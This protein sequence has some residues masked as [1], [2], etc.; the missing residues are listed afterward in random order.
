M[1]NKSVLI[2]GANIGLGK[3]VARQLALINETEKIYLGCRNAQ[4]ADE[5]KRE[6]V[7][8]TGRAIFEIVILDVSDPAS[9]S[10]A[11]SGMKQPVDALILNAGGQ[12]GK[13]PLAIT[14]TGMTNIA[15][16]NLL[17]HVVLVDEMI[18]AGK[19]NNEVLYVSSEGARGI[20]GVM[21]KPNLKSNSVAEFVSVLDGSF[22]NPKFDGSEAYGYGY[23]K[24]IGALWTSANARKYP[25]IKF[26][27][28]SPGNTSGTAGYDN[29]PGMTKFLFKYLLAPIVMPLIGMIHS[30]QK[31]AARY[32]EALGNANLKSGMFYGS[33][34]GKVTGAMVEQGTIFP[35]FRNITFQDNAYEA[36]HSFI[37]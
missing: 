31:G 34:D 7:S 11:V 8:L 16:T 25:Q 2:T 30:I 23:I 13:E 28:I 18:K 3:E 29:L 14:S 36:L 22:S 1:K 15:A 9:V 19:L 27:S 35:E 12:G 33:K 4:K 20:K 6:L 21:K 37:K 10:A 5:A 24:Y 26:I 32:V 17:G